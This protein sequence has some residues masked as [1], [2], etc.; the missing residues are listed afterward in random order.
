MLYFIKYCYHYV[1]YWKKAVKYLFGS[2]NR[3]N[4]GIRLLLNN[5]SKLNRSKK[6]FEK[7]KHMSLMVNDRNENILNKYST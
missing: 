4:N 7:V 3:S 1:S 6:R 5:L 2:V